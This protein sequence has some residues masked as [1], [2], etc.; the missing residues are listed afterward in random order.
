[1]YIL[2]LLYYYNCPHYLD[3]RKQV[4]NSPEVQKK[5]KPYEG[6]FK[7]LTI[8]TGANIST[9]EDVFFLDNLFQTLVS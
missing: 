9:P 5:L 2:Q 3:V 1:M 8:K 6:L 7:F 4:Y